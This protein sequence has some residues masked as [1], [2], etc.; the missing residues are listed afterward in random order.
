[1]VPF[2][3]YAPTRWTVVKNNHV[4]VAFLELTGM[5]HHIGRWRSWRFGTLWRCGALWWALWRCWALWWAL[6]WALWRCGALWW[7]WSLGL[8]SQLD[9]SGSNGLSRPFC[10]A[11]LVFVRLFQSFEIRR[12][13]VIGRNFEANEFKQIGIRIAIFDFMRKVRDCS[14]KNTQKMRHKKEFHVLCVV[15]N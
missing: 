11:L 12:L 7:P 2:F 9:D 15:R 8:T 1:M 13:F 4:G 14:V 3:E 5:V 10:E 6:C